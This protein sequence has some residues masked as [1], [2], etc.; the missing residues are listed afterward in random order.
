MN[1]LN[2]LKFALI[3]KKKL[4]NQ[5][6]AIKFKQSNTWLNPKYYNI[7]MVVWRWRAK[8]K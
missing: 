5:L 2:P 4:M 1:K 8:T 3:A 7:W 6:Y